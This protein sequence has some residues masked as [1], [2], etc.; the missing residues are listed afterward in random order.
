MS[1]DEERSGI[2]SIWD[3]ATLPVI[4]IREM[5]QERWQVNRVFLKQE[6]VSLGH[7]LKEVL[8]TCSWQPGGR[9][10]SY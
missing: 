5:V 1:K 9:R 6:I 4:I 7:D 10:D 3:V 8:T 2:G